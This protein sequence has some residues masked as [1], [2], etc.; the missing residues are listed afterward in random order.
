MR[1]GE[2]FIFCCYSSGSFSNFNSV[3]R[4]AIS[5]LSTSAPV[6]VFVAVA[7]V[8]VAVYLKFPRYFRYS[9]VSSVFS[10]CCVGTACLRRNREVGSWIL[11]RKINYSEM[12]RRASELQHTGPLLSELP[13]VTPHMTLW[14]N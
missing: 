10:V 2:N 9:C 1:R 5:E 3:A 6:R 14:R 12:R 8:Y 7:A 13:V 4:R 11:S